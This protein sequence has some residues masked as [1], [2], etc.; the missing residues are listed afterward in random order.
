[1]AK[2]IHLVSTI[3]L[4]THAFSRNARIHTNQPRSSPIPSSSR[5]IVGDGLADHRTR[6]ADSCALQV[7]EARVARIQ[8]Q[9]PSHSANP[10]FHGPELDRS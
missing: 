10:F 2:K 1:M 6:V 4:R 5:M 7:G 9:R 3:V 8:A